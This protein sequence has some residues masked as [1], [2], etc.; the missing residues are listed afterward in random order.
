MLKFETLRVDGAPCIATIIPEDEI[1]AL[2]HGMTDPSTLTP[3][4]N[5]LIEIMGTSEGWR[6]ISNLRAI[7][8]Q[9]NI[10]YREQRA[11]ALRDLFSDLGRLGAR[12]GIEGGIHFGIGTDKNRS[13]DGRLPMYFYFDWP[14]KDGAA[15]T[16]TTT[17]FMRDTAQAIGYENGQK[18]RYRGTVGAYIDRQAGVRLLTEPLMACE[19]STAGS[20]YD[21]AEE[22]VE[23]SAHNLY[24][25]DQQLICLAGALTLA[26]H[27]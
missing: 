1:E 8:R 22:R 15:L 5:E 21:P 25:A 2:R 6:L 16:E 23:L 19:L 7:K 10:Q 13:T 18:G 24:S 14:S 27:D 12:V 3:I 9:R 20:N 4:D 11:A 17:A 26:Q